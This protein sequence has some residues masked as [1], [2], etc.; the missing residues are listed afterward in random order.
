[1]KTNYVVLFGATGLIGNRLGALLTQQGYQ[2]RAVL[3]PGAS[4]EH[5]LFEPYDV[6]YADLSNIEQL[7]K[8]V[9]DAKA[10]LYFIS[11]SIPK[12]SYNDPSIELSS[13]LPALLN[14]L[15]AMVNQKSNARLIFPSTGGAIY[16]SCDET[17]AS[18]ET[19]LAP[20]SGYAL[21]KAMSEQLIQFYA[22]RFDIAYTILRISNVYGCAHPR[23][24]AQGIIDVFLD[25]TLK[26]Q[27][28]PIWGS[29]HVERDYIFVD[30]VAS[31]V[32]KVLSSSSTNK[33]YNIGASKS[34]SLKQIL[35]IIDVITEK[36]HRYNIESNEFQGVQR[37]AIDCSL[38]KSDTAWEPEVSLE[39][40]IRQTW[41]R[42]CAYQKV[43]NIS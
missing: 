14:L 22:R 17:S 30:D 38:F 29:L 6:V 5:L 1:M 16:G 41:L 11:T 23:K 26:G 36:A 24:I 28:S 4:A 19:D 13:S 34:Y 10:I 9:A 3:R 21:G 18:E 20:L 25:N 37:S 39:E 32:A 7:E 15:K 8:A 42:K 27:T 33:I 31:A 43:H 2:V 40:G 12:S 35:E